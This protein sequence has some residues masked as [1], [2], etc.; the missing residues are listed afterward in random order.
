MFGK[1]ELLSALKTALMLNNA[2]L[3]FAGDLP[4]ILVPQMMHR[5]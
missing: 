4:E 3:H 1:W 2:V 5:T